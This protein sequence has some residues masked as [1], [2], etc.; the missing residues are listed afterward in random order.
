MAASTGYQGRQRFG[1]NVYIV[2][3]TVLD[4]QLKH[5]RPIEGDTSACPLLKLSS[6]SRRFP[7]SVRPGRH[8]N[9]SLTSNM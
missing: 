7:E 6:G 9:A 3:S 1:L 8:P 2:C 4:K 5:I